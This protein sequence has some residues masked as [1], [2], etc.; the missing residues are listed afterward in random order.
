MTRPTVDELL[1]ASAPQDVYE[2]PGMRERVALAV[3]EGAKKR[4]RA[5]IALPVAVCGIAALSAGA[6]VADNLMTQDVV[7]PISYVTDTGKSIECTVKVGG[8]SSFDPKSTAIPDWFRAHDWDGVGQRIYDRA[9]TIDP[10]EGLVGNDGLSQ[11]TLDHFAFGDALNAEI[12]YIV[13]ADVL[14]PGFAEVGASWDCDGIL[15]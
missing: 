3:A 6:L 10:S 11:K 13:P 14:G 9:L 4:H 15:H 5:W 7:I 12:V 8:G 1:R 2:E